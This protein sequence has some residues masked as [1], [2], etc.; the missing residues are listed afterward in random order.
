MD[1]LRGYFQKF[2]DVLK[3]NLDSSI[4]RFE[5]GVQGFLEYLGSKLPLEFQNLV[6]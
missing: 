3:L 2:P 5:I 4:T 6:H 1:R